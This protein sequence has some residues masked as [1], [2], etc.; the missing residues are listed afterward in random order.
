VNRRAKRYRGKERKEGEEWTRLCF[1][2]TGSTSTVQY[3]T[4]LHYDVV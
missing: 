4:V 3:S 1:V 2:Q